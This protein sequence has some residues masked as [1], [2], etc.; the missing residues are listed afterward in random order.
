MRAK[1]KDTNQPALE[2]ELKELGFSVQS[3]HELGKGVPDLLVGVY[4]VN[5]VLEV[6]HDNAALTQPEID[7][8]KDWKGQARIVQ[9]TEESLLYMS[10]YVQSLRRKLDSVTDHC[11]LALAKLRQTKGD[12]NEGE[13]SSNIPSDT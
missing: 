2:A 13:L 8:H 6:K 9:S 11:D 7:W 3:L 12:D 4:G 10:S 1:R 5:F